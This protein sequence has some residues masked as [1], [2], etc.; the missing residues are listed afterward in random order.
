MRRQIRARGD[1]SEMAPDWTK[2]PRW[3]I[4]V[5]A[6]LAFCLLAAFL[7]GLV[8]MQRHAGWAVLTLVGGDGLILLI[9]EVLAERAHKRDLYSS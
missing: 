6:A 1:G 8:L 4:I 3:K 5:I 9:S 7:C 2:P